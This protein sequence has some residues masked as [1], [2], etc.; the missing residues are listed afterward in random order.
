VLR[1]GGL[2]AVRLRDARARGLADGEMDGDSLH[3]PLRSG[4]GQPV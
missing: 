3:D 2:V 1:A 4:R